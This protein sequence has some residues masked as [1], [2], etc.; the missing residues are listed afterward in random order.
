[1]LGMRGSA[2]QEGLQKWET[3]KRPTPPLKEASS[4]RKQRASAMPEKNFSINLA[5]SPNSCVI[6]LG[7][8][9]YRALVDTGAE[10]SLVHRRVF[11]KLKH[12]YDLG[13]QKVNLQAVNGNKLQVDGCATIK[14][15]LGGRKFQHTFY[16]VDGLNRNVILGRDWI[17]DNKVVLYFNELRSMKIGP[18]VCATGRGHPH[19]GPRSSSQYGGH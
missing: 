11:D 15:K 12:G 6:Q 14:F 17:I 5:G 1:M 9:R 4:E 18:G 7:K 16:V 19:F 2:L 8:Q 13:K 10:V 3:K